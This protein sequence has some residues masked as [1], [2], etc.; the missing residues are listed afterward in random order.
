MVVFKYEKIVRYI[1]TLNGGLIGEL[2]IQNNESEIRICTG[3]NANK[4]VAKQPICILSGQ[5]LNKGKGIQILY[6]DH[7]AL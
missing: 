2:F 7:L 5:I 4:L 1:Q 3:L 6:I